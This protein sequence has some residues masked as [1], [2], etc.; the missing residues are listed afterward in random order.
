MNPQLPQTGGSAVWQLIF[1]SFALVLILFEILRGWRRGVARQL[2]RL[3]ALIA[4]YFAAL[5]G[6]KLLV[7][8]VRPFLTMP[9]FALSIVAGVVLALVVYGVIN[10]LGTVFF[11]R[12]NQH[13]STMVRL[14]F[15]VGGAVLGIFF[16]AFFIWLI[17]VG[18]RSVG[19]IADSK[20]RSDSSTKNATGELIHAVDER[21]EMFG[22]LTE[23]TPSL[24]PSLAQLKNSL[25][26]G[27]VGNI[28][29]RADIVPAQTY[30]ALGKI[31][32][33]VSNPGAAERLLS[34]PGTRELAEHPKIIALRNDPEISEMI[35]QGRYL[36]LLQ[37]EKLIDAANDPDLRARLKRFDLN[38][39]L[40]YAVKKK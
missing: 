6:G 15:G 7:P 10:A 1:L 18:I 33:V 19:A 2:A 12:T 35:E 34:F 20:L 40:D 37:N 23:P 28:V 25:E 30:A 32:T 3:G 31:G 9:D 27:P 11:R 16:G 39:A 8:L 5:F 26:T 36:E 22:E 21:R 24:V 14:V 13:K 17:V 29:E 38:E 4:A